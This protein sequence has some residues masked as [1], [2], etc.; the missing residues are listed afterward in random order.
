MSI[1]D[2]A[3][4]GPPA[5]KAAGPRPAALAD[6]ELL[7]LLLRTG[8]PGQGVLQLAE[9]VLGAFERLVRACCTPGAAT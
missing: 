1:K 8:L 7:A 4:R 2:I 5:R 3:R 9:A 6:V